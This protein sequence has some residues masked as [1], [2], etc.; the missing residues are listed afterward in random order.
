MKGKDGKKFRKLIYLLK[1]SWLDDDSGGVVH[2]G[3]GCCL[4]D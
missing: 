3:G 2:G 1:S 4:A